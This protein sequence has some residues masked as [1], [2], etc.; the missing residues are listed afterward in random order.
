M[1]LEFLRIGYRQPNGMP[2]PR[3]L[4]TREPIENEI[5]APER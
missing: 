2:Q 4:H 1:L 5:T 3:T